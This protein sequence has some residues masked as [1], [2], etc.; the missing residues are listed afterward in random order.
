M[1]EIFDIIVAVNRLKD[2]VIE[3]SSRIDYLYKYPSIIATDKLVEEVAARKM[4]HCG[5]STL[6]LMCEKGEIT[7]CVQHHKRLFH[8]DSINEYIAKMSHPD[9]NPAVNPLTTKER[10]D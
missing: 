10:E 5:R 9:R 3:L 4:L 6:Y 1:S 2:K 7:F 8:V